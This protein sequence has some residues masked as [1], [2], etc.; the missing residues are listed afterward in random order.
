M[1]YPI[2]VFPNNSTIDA[3]L[4][5]S[6]GF[7][8]YGNDL[9]CVRLLLYNEF[10]N[11]LIMEVIG[12]GQNNLANK[13][14]E[15][16]SDIL[17]KQFVSYVL[18][19]PRGDKR[20]I[21][22][23]MT[24]RYNLWIAQ[25]KIDQFLFQGGL[26]GIF[27]NQSLL[28]VANTLLHPP[29]EYTTDITKCGFFQDIEIG[30]ERRHIIGSYY[31]DDNN[32]QIVVDTP[33]TQQ[34][35]VGTQYRVYCNYVV[36]PE[37]TFKTRK[38]PEYEITPLGDKYLSDGGSSWFMK[39]SQENNLLI[40]SF[41][42]TILDITENRMPIYQGKIYTP[43]NSNFKI[44]RT[45]SESKNLTSKKNT[46]YQIN[47][48]NTLSETTLPDD[49]V[50]LEIVWNDLFNYGLFDDKAHYVYVSGS[51]EHQ[52]GSEENIQLYKTNFFYRGDSGSEKLVYYIKDF[53]PNQ[54][55]TVKYYNTF[56][57]ILGTCS[58]ANATGGKGYRFEITELYQETTAK[59]IGFNVVEM[60]NISQDD[61]NHNFS[62]VING[63]SFTSFAETR[64]YMLVSNQPLN[65]TY[66]LKE[67][68]S[69]SDMNTSNDYYTQGFSY[70]LNVIYIEKHLSNILNKE[71]RI[72]DDNFYTSK[73]ITGYNS[74]SG[75]VTLNSQLEKYPS[76]DS[77]YQIFGKSGDVTLDKTND[78]YR[79][80]T[81]FKSNYL[82]IDRWLQG[83]IEFRMENDTVFYASISQGFPQSVKNEDGSPFDIMDFIEDDKKIISNFDAEL[84]SLNINFKFL[85][86]YITN[87]QHVSIYREEENR[88]K[89][90]L[91]YNFNVVENSTSELGFNEFY[92]D[93]IISYSDY[94]VANNM[95]YRYVILLQVQSTGD[96]NTIDYKYYK[97]ITDWFTCNSDSWSII[98]LTKHGYNRCNKPSYYPAEVWQLR[99]EVEPDDIVQNINV[100]TYNGYSTYPKVAK[101]GNN[102]ISS[103]ISALLGDI[104]CRTQ[105]FNDTIQKVNAWR[106]FITSYETYVL[107]TSKGDIWH[108]SIADNP[109]TKYSETEDTTTIS[110]SYT[111]INDIHDIYIGT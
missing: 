75:L 51:V 89:Q 34:L 49:K 87:S 29:I 40:K 84:S 95:K 25:S 80:N 97:Y 106:K 38:S 45:I 109:T 91:M 86:N 111:Q 54:D 104:D 71:I 74:S 27:D 9:T 58:L 39:Y 2:N 35:S 41:N 64:Y 8:F 6:F 103:S 78:I 56:G 37:Y 46:L 1:K 36:S 60:S 5:Q 76:V 57:N 10:T 31:Y 66:N 18:T 70:N 28:V 50:Y 12:F 42:W 24:C 3:D 81:F 4:F 11:N 105:V 69:I 23:G 99:A 26:T 63:S 102:Y 101:L 83:I 77:K 82:A 61:I 30:G 94:T 47:G 93:S 96:D 85:S 43:N 90:D 72:F 48:Y 98:G 33:F 7:E 17:N 20:A 44:T 22:N 92:A 107:R 53:S 52:Y 32:Y 55:I 13:T 21:I 62:V 79:I 16:S 67:T 68:K 14:Q 108:V 65:I 73:T 100:Q 59:E 110:F 88:V 19:D 15:P